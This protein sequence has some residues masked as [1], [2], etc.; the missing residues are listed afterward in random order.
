MTGRRRKSFLVHDEIQGKYL[1][2]L[3]GPT[4]TLP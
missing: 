4:A 3:C 1:T 2:E